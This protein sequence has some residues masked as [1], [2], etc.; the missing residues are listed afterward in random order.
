VAL[1]LTGLGFAPLYPSMMHET[2]KRF[3]VSNGALLIGLQVGVSYVGGTLITNLL[4]QWFAWTSIDWLYPII[5]SLNLLMMIVS[6][7]YKR[8]SK[9]FESST[10]TVI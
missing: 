8:S 2:P 9:Q 1:I 5:L 4:G 6:E 3:T 10:S 7:F